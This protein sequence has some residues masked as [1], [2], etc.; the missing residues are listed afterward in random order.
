[1][2]CL[3]WVDVVD[4]WVDVAAAC[5]GETWTT[6][7]CQVL[8]KTGNFWSSAP[9][10]TQWFEPLWLFRMPRRIVIDKF[11]TLRIWKINC[12]DLL[13][14]PGKPRLSASPSHRH[15]IPISSLLIP[16]SSHSLPQNFAGFVSRPIT[17]LTPGFP[18]KTCAANSMILYKM[19][20]SGVIV[21]KLPHALTSPYALTSQT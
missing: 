14:A 2:W 7:K 1:M 16:F 19:S 10:S 11:L 21:R 15:L 20:R 8:N 18:P 17:K 4:V 9:C 5:G 12:P 6:S 13:E 3:W